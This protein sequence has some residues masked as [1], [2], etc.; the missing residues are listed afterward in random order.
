MFLAAMGD[1]GRHTA[2]LCMCVVLMYVCAAV[3]VKRWP[4][5]A[6]EA[7]GHFECFLPFCTTSFERFSP[8]SGNCRFR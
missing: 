8:E 4:M 1:H 7:M 2:G 6:C 5:P 3:Y